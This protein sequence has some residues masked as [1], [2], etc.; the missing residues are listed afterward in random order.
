MRIKLKSLAVIILFGSSCFCQEREKSFDHQLELSLFGGITT[1]SNLEPKFGYM[2][3]VSYTVRN[4]KKRVRLSMGASI[5]HY[6]T[7]TQ[8]KYNSYNPK[9]DTF[10]VLHWNNVF[11][12]FQLSMDFILVENDLTKFYLTI[13]WNVG[14]Y[15]AR[16]RTSKRYDESQGDKLISESMIDVG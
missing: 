8:K 5:N 6:R 2:Y 4:P 11:Y 9:S 13:G 15:I 10:S 3:G 12:E 1:Q 16:D 14:S 7:K